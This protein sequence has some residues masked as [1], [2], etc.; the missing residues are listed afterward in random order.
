MMYDY[1]NKHKNID[2]LNDHMFI[3]TLSMFEYDSLPE[4]LPVFEI[5]KQLQKNG[6]TFITKVNGELYAFSGGLGG[7]PDVYGQ[8]TE[9][10]ISNP[11]LNFN[12]TLDINKDGVL[13]N[14]DD[15]RLGLTP[16]FNK[17]N[18]LLIE[19]EITMFINTYNTRVQTL[20]SA[21][22]DNTRES[23]EQFLKKIEDG[24]LG[25]IGE[26]RLFDGI[27][28][29]SGQTNNSNITTQLI[30]FN[31]YVK[32]SLYHEVG[33][34]SNF[35]MKR[36]RL[37]SSEVKM[38]REGLF[39]FIHNMLVNRQNA[40]IKLNDMFG[41]NVSVAFGSVWEDKEEEEI[42]EIENVP[43]ETIPYDELLQSYLDDKQNNPDDEVLLKEYE[44]LLSEY[45]EHKEVENNAI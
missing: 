13:I 17:Y 20:L 36:E 18:T 14:N 40:M 32:A 34:D 26:N 37:N 11:Y 8:P 43:R 35:N 10:V 33:L 25:V 44:I 31:Q 12:E 2:I 15:L 5:E 45:P 22:D 30:E 39:P 4:T 21:G 19:N 16:I 23:A 29:N 3:R 41:L 1:K 28:V 38:H 27:K 7:V 24:E 6:Y 42:E 9:I